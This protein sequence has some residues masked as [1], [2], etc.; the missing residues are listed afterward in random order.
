MKKIFTLFIYCLIAF[1]CMAEDTT[2]T[3][4]END[5]NRD[6]RGEDNRSLTIYPTASHNENILM[7]HSNACIEN[8]QVLI[9]DTTGNVVYSNVIT[10]IGESTLLLPN[11]SEGIYHLN[12]Y[13]GDVYLYGNFK[14]E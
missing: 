4:V 13:Y 1:N 10:L 8:L 5:G 12:L 6:E 2:I 9:I 3:L 7:L 14:I 11:L